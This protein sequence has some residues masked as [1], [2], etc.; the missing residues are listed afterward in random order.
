M[1]GAARR[2]PELRRWLKAIR[3]GALKVSERVT[4]DWIAYAGLNAVGVAVILHVTIARRWP[5][6]AAG[7]AAQ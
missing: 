1:A 7:T 3:H 5:F 6:G 2:S 4:E